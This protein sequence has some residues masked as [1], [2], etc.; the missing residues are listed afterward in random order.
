[1]EILNEVGATVNKNEC[2]FFANETE[3]IEYLIDKNGIR[4]NPRKIHPI[5]N[6]PQPTNIKQLQSFLGAVNYYP[7]F[8][9]NMADIAKH[10]NK[11]IDKNAIWG[12]KSECDN[13][14]QVLKRRLSETP[15]LS[16]YGRNIPLKVDCN[17][18]I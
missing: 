10:L 13:S 7:K 11:F 3:Y 1:M 5:I 15:V 9:P 4:V 8:I 17:A 16:M 12:W 6:I 2:L 14:F 18:S